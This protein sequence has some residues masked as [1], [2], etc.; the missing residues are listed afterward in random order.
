MFSSTTIESSTTRPIAMVSAPRVSRFSERSPV[1]SA[2]SA[3]TTDSGIDTAVTRVERSDIRNSRI[4]RT[5]NAS[6]S[7]PSVVSPPIASLTGVPWSNTTLIS[8]PIFF[9][10]SGSLSRTE[11]EM[12]TAFPLSTMVTDRPRLGLPLVRVMDV[13]GANPAWTSATSPSFTGFPAGAPGRGAGF[14]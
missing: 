13:G 8:A 12:A 3:T 1:H 14:R 11:S 4:T 5:A 2:S 10:S 6:P 9:D 7:R